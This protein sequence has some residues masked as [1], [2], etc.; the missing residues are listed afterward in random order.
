MVMGSGFLAGEP[1]LLELVVDQETSII[2]GGGRTE[3]A[4][5]NG[6]GAFS[7]SL[8]EIG[9]HDSVQAMAAGPRSILATGADG[10]TA[11]KPVLIIASPEL[12]TAV[13]STLAAA[14]TVADN[15]ISIWGSGFQPGEAVLFSVVGAAA[16]GEDRILAGTEAN[17]SG[18]FSYEADNPIA[19]GTYTLRADGSLGSS[20]TAPLAVVEEK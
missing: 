17:S 10:S 20:A 5:A 6:S 19:V 9:G 3:Q 8:D 11:S 1:V 14:A 2:I 18:A 13:D 15:P 7:V 16:G 4:Q 12:Q